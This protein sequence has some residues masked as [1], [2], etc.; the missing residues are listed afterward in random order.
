MAST[1]TA[2]IKKIDL[3][4]WN[5]WLPFSWRMW[6]WPSYCKSPWY[7][8]SSSW[9]SR[10]SFLALRSVGSDEVSSSR[11]AQSFCSKHVHLDFHGD[12]STR[13]QGVQPVLI[14]D[15][16][17]IREVPDSSEDALKWLLTLLDLGLL[18]LAMSPRSWAVWIVD[19]VDHLEGLFIKLGPVWRLWIRTDDG[20]LEPGSSCGPV[21]PNSLVDLLNTWV[22]EE[23]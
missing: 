9:Y 8:V 7:C 21:L 16:K 12:G 19:D 13:S 14:C 17:R 2:T 3:G 23:E 10:R 22:S 15:G 1:K 4:Y 5:T 11:L 20:V 18:R 6:G